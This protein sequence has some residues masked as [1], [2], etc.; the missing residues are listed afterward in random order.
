MKVKAVLSL[1]LLLVTVATASAAT[2]SAATDFEQQ[3]ATQ[4]LAVQYDL[5]KAVVVFSGYLQKGWQD[6]GTVT[7][8][9]DWKRIYLVVIPTAESG[10]RIIIK[11]NG[12]GQAAVLGGLSARNILAS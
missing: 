3:L 2:D 4:Q 7:V 5:S 9:K 11:V 10:N 6:L 12:G 8:L 1:L